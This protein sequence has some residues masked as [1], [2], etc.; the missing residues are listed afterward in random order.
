MSTITNRETSSQSD[1]QSVERLAPPIVVP[2]SPRDFREHVSLPVSFRNIP[3][4]VGTFFSIIAT[5]WVFLLMSA[6][7]SA[8]SSRA[9]GRTP[10]TE[11]A[12]PSDPESAA[13]TTSTPES[14]AASLSSQPMH[15]NAPQES[16]SSNDSGATVM[17]LQAS[18]AGSPR[19]RSQSNEAAEKATAHDTPPPTSPDAVGA[20]SPIQTVGSATARDATAPRL[21]FRPRS[22]NAPSQPAV[23]EADGENVL[24]VAAK[25]A[26]DSVATTA[27][28]PTSRSPNGPDVASTGPAREAKAAAKLEER[29]PARAAR[30]R[31]KNPE[32]GSPVPVVIPASPIA[33]I[34]AE[35]GVEP[36]A[37][38]APMI[39][40]LGAMTKEL[41][42]AQRTIG[43]LVAERDALRKQ[44]VE[45]DGVPFELPEDNTIR[46]AKEAR[47]EARAIKQADRIN[48]LETPPDVDPAIRAADAGRR[49]RRIA[50]AI[51]LVLV[52]SFYWA[53]MQGW[54]LGDFLSKGGLSSIAYVGPF[55]NVFLAGW[56]LFRVVRVGGKGARWLFPEPEEPGRR[57]RRR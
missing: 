3:I 48:V 19:S 27:P 23:N 57:Q 12:T 28:A 46:I 5:S 35:E 43:R 18:S 39:H 44:V 50:A 36:E 4:I 11:T 56:L 33:T 8:A 13:A 7:G 41:T 49:R 9:R 38:L 24:P 32:P 31:A 37:G 10:R 2:A 42:N 47:V 16:S 30:R 26:A 6:T 25:S 1:Q 51:V 34:P 40:H 21:N 52:A 15:T 29:N 54:N 20:K 53:D 45:L 22:P 17:A 14:T 55:F